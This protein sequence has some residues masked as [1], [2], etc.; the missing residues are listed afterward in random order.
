[1]LFFEE[2]CSKLNIDWSDITSNDLFSETELTRWLTIARD[3]IVAKHPWPITEGKRDLAVVGG[4]EEYRYWSD[5]KSDSIRYLS[6]NGKRYRKLLFESYLKYREDYSS[7]QG[8]YFS[9]RARR[10]YIN[11]LVTD[12]ANT[13]RAYGQI[14]VSIAINS[15][16][17]TTIFSDAEPEIDE[18]IIQL[19][20][21]IA[22]SSEKMKNP[23]QGRKERTE[24]FEKVDGI[25]DKIATRQHTYQTKDK[26][27]FRKLN[28]LEGTIGGENNP[29]QF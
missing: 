26:P 24:S 12:F 13:I 19:A 22:L 6:V 29:L 23:T 8:R 11:P 2:F 27:M 28:I 25:W 16:I 18:A 17:T 5:M 9:D 1:M 7:G 15:T 20:Y 14:Q 21:S 4:Q 10:I 3:E